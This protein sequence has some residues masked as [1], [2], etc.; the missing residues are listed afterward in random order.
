ML[1]DIH[2]YMEKDVNLFVK[3]YTNTT[4]TAN[5]YLL[6]RAADVSGSTYIEFDK[7]AQLEDRTWYCLRE[8]RVFGDK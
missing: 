1:K 2:N 4:V 3:L 6:V 8:F 7:R 5:K